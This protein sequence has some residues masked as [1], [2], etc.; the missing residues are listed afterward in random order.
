MSETTR[1]SAKSKPFIG[2]C[3]HILPER[4]GRP[5]TLE[6]VQIP[7]RVYGLACDSLVVRIFARS[8]IGPGFESPSG[9]MIFLHDRHLP[10]P[11]D[12]T[13]TRTQDPLRMRVYSYHRTV[14]PKSRQCDIGF[15][16]ESSRSD[17]SLLINIKQKTYFKA[18]I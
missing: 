15:D 2:V 6:G 9:H 11:P 18:R 1:G 14:G 4:R 12:P 8:A 16:P 3:I 5:Q 17:L 10:P 7:C 13:R